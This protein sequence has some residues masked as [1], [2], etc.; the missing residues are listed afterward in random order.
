MP[1]HE[2][3]FQ[4]IVQIQVGNEGFGEE[5]NKFVRGSLTRIGGTTS[6]SD[7]MYFIRNKQTGLYLSANVYSGVMTKPFDNSDSAFSTK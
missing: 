2:G 6:T 5:G 4:P 7:G 1:V 3:Q